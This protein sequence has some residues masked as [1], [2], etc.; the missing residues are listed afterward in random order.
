VLARAI[1]IWVAGL[2]TL[3]PYG[4]YYLFFEAQ[5]DQYA[6]LVILVLFW[7]FG[8]WGVAG[9]L[10]VAIKV[11]KVFRALEQAK[12]R[13]ELLAQ[14]R[15]PEAEAVAIELIASENHIPRFLAAHVLKLVVNR[16][17]SA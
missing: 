2:L 3:V 1:V 16:F 7:I 17:S 6:F 9:P 10:L 12:S 4:T 15:N 11:R 8:F 14:L 13:E 5:R